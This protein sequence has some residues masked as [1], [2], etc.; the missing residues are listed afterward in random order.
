MLY[1]L[2]GGLVYLEGSEAEV[3]VLLLG[4]LCKRVH[5]LG[6]N[7]LGACLVRKRAHCVYLKFWLAGQVGEQSSHSI[8]CFAWKMGAF[9]A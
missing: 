1:I 4:S 3:L 2:Y 5:S 8:V 9:G 6:T 7:W